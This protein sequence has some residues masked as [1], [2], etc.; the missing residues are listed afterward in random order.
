MAVQ[1]NSA[2]QCSPGLLQLQLRKPRSRLRLFRCP[3]TLHRLELALQ[4][5]TLLLRRQLITTPF[6]AR[7]V[8]ICHRHTP[9][10]SFQ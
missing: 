5:S 2:T 8:R 6:L 9:C 3:R 10:S 1:C 4:R 7:R